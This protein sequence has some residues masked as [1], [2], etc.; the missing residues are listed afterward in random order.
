M[1]YA[2][3]L[4][5]RIALVCVQD[6][7]IVSREQN[8][9]LSITTSRRFC[10]P[11][12]IGHNQMGVFRDRSMRLRGG[13]SQIIE[14]WI[15]ALGKQS[16]QIHIYRWEHSKCSYYLLSP[17]SNPQNSYGTKTRGL[18]KVARLLWVAMRSTRTA[19]GTFVSNV[20]QRLIGI[21]KFHSV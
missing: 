13:F 18:R 19:H 15:A 5:N 21:Q 17:Y 3:R 8:R 16:R 6:N 11:T 4:S 12:Q 9:E 2:F 20:G 14:T 7:R 1:L 10:A